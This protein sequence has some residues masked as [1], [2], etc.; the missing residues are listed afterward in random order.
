MV[1]AC[2]LSRSAISPAHRNARLHL[3]QLV[4]HRLEG[5]HRPSEGLPVHDVL[6]G[7][8]EHVLAGGNGYDRDTE[9][10]LGELV[11]QLVEAT[12]LATKDVRGRYADVLEEQLGGVLT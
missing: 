11:H 5:R 10:L 12:V 4:L 3:R 7:Q 9:T 6:P 1:N 2:V 8:F